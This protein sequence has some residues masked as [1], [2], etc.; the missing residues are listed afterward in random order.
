M[1]YVVG[2]I[3]AMQLKWIKEIEPVLKAGDILIC[4]GDF[5]F[6][7]WDGLYWPE[8]MFYDHISKLEFTVL[9]VDGNHEN[10]SKLNSYPVELWNGG[11][12]HKIRENLI[13]LMRGEIY[14]IEGKRIFTFG[15]GYSVDKPYRTEGVSWWPEEMPS[16]EEY[17]NAEENLKRANYKVDYIITHTASKESISYL[18]TIRGLGIK[19]DV[20]E[21][22]TLNTFLDKI[23][24]QVSYERWFIGHFHIDIE[25]WKNQIFLISTIREL[26]TGNVVKRWVSYE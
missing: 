7:F 24:N 17:T 2:D 12:V 6:G 18:S 21:E 20:V 3:H 15:G 26:E 25:L 11:R 22:L 23:Q 10:F 8:E 13:H 19:N 4:A 14:E 16:E 1:I 9:V 5:G